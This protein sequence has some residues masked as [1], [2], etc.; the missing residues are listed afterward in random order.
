MRWTTTTTPRAAPVVVLLVAA[1]GLVG[2]SSSP[3]TK[4]ATSA[5][6]PLSINL[7][8]NATL[9]T[10]TG[11]VAAVPMGALGDPLNTFWQLFFRS[12]NATRWALVTPP[13]VADNGGLVVS[14]DPGPGG[15]SSWLVGFEPSQALDFSPLALSANQGV[16]WSPGFITDGLAPVPDALSTSAGAGLVALVRARGGAVLRST[17]NISTWSELVSRGAIASTAAGRS[18]GVG[19]LTAVVLVPSRGVEVGTACSAPGVVGIF[20]RVGASWRLVGPRLSGRTGAARTQ[21]LRLVDANGVTSGL[22]AVGAKSGTSLIG[23]ARTT[24]G[25]WSSSVPLAL[26]RRGRVVSTGVEVGGGYVVLVSGFNRSL[27]IDTETGPGA[28]WRALPAPPLGTAAVAVGTNG[29]VD[30]LEVAATLL[31]DWR[32]D[33]SAGTWSK[34]GTVTVP[35]QFGSSS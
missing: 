25:V 16:S 27:A 4:G 1:T 8:L 31:T 2:C 9:A 29:E 7:P 3:P 28:D 20:G 30:A 19:E 14:P 33:A 12:T 10:G 22:V 18:C 26:G 11:V 5:V 34:I 17:G 23:V 21:V 35:I 6:S 32:L 15:A 13:G 24:A